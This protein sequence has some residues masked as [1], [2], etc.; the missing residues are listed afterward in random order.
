LLSIYSLNSFAARRVVETLF[1]EENP[2][3]EP[4]DERALYYYISFFLSKVGF[5]KTES[6]A[7]C[8][9]QSSDML[10]ASSSTLLFVA[11]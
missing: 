10:W 5:S 9:G 7:L 1:L 2:T 6:A 3:S 8:A 4:L 11:S